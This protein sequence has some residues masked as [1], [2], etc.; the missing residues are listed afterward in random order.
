MIRLKSYDNDLLEYSVSYVD[1]TNTIIDVVT[2]ENI[3]LKKLSYEIIKKI[4]SR[5]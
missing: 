4:F 3:L 1:I 5:L 2:A